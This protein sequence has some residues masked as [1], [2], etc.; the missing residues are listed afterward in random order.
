MAPQRRTVIRFR[1][2]FDYDPGQKLAPHWRLGLQTRI[3]REQGDSLCKTIGQVLV[4]HPQIAAAWT[5]EDRDR[6]MY[7]RI[8]ALPCIYQRD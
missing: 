3:N 8:K 1:K 2:H 4:Q 5:P 6:A 7:N